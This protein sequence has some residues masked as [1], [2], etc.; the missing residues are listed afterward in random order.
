MHYRFIATGLL[1]TTISLLLVVWLVVFRSAAAPTAVSPSGITAVSSPSAMAEGV[2]RPADGAVYYGVQL[3]WQQDSIAQYVARLGREPV[4]FGHYAH[5]PLMAADRDGLTE[6]TSQ[7]ETAGGKL[8]LTLMPHQ[9]LAAVDEGAILELAALLA[10]YNRRGIEVLVRYGP[11]M[12]GSWYSWGLRAEEYV[13]SFRRVAQAVHESAPGSVMVWSPY[14]G[15]GYPFPSQEY[16]LPPNAAELEA[17][18]TNHDGLLDMNDDPY[19]PYYPGDEYVDWVALTDYHRGNRW[20]WGDNQVPIADQL[21]SRLLGRYNGP[22]ADERSVPNFYQ[23]YAEDK[24]KPFALAETAALFDPSLVGGDAEAD[25]K[26]AWAKQAFSPRLAADF[27]Q[28]KLVMWFEYA[29]EERDVG[30]VDWR[31]TQERAV[32]REYQRALGPHLVFA[33]NE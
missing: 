17:I 9:G 31:A 4:V 20:P 6:A 3:D 29:K 11:E 23:Q 12:N 16:D 21:R 1:A 25:I 15:G 33:P 10:D 2:S 24:D 32:L 19:A 26:S 5:F 30:F 14:Y 28:L 7:I 13:A 8:L 18:D 27:P 22:I